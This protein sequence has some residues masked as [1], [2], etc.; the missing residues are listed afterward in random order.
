MTAIA[1]E[2]TVAASLATAAAAERMQAV[3]MQATR[4]GMTLAALLEW[5]GADLEAQC[6]APS[7]AA[8]RTAVTAIRRA[9]EGGVR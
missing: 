3:R 2:Q 8:F 1:I 9:V 5:Y 6:A 7:P 4:R